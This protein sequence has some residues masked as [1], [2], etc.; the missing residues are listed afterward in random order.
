MKTYSSC[1]EGNMAHILSREVLTDI[2]ATY[3]MREDKRGQAD[4]EAGL[5][6]GDYVSKKAEAARAQGGL[7]DQAKSR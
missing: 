5:W 6:G 3:L 1:Q 4:P 2:L 7:I